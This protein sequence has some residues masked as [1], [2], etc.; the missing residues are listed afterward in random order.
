MLEGVHHVSIN[1]K[2]VDAALGFYVEL[3]GM[4]LLPR[5]ELGFP[6]AWMRAGEQEVHLLQVDSGPPPKQ[7]HFAF[8]VAD[9]DAVRAALEAAGH[10]CSQPMEIAGICRQTFARDP[11]DN[12][13]EFNQRL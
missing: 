9:V 1:V 11:S 10:N 5:P 13:V 7:Q 8:K 6:G 3:L 12:L 2:D 4:E